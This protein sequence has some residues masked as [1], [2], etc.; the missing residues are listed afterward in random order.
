MKIRNLIET[1]LFAGMLFTAILVL[2]M[3][4]GHIEYFT[5]WENCYRV[6]VTTSFT[7]MPAITMAFDDAV[8]E[9]T[10]K[11]VKN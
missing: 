7:L 9:D 2:V 1:A 6:A 11:E 3:C 4:I 10:I 5:E 8:A